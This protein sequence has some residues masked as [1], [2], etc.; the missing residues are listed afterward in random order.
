MLA[1][2]KP[3]FTLGLTATTDRMDGENLLEIFKNVAHKLDLKTAV[4][5]G[6]L[7]PIRCM[8]IKTNV[9]LSTVRINGIKYNSQEMFEHMDENG[10]VKLEDIVDY[11]IDFYTARKNKGLVIDFT[12][13]GHTPAGSPVFEANP[14]GAPANVLAAVSKLGGKSAFIG[15][16]GDDQFGHFLEEVLKSH[17]ID[18]AGLSFSDS[19]NTTLA[20]VHL[21]QKGERSFSFYGGS[22]I[23]YLQNWYCPHCLYVI[24]NPGF[25][26]VMPFSC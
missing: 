9:D 8:R 26:G 22:F 16:V 18:T 13:A 1:Y 4:E 25:A 21:D 24:R 19:V 3:E 10:R 7:V 5:I 14:G 2:F 6:E 17:G 23:R 15:K 20:F 11:F 12:P